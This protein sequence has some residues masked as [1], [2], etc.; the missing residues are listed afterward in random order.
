MVNGKP[1]VECEFIMPTIQPN[2]KTVKITFEKKIDSSW[3]NG[4]YMANLFV[5][6]GQGRVL[7]VDSADF[8]V[9][10][11]ESVDVT[12]VYFT[13]VVAGLSIGGFLLGRRFL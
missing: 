11:P 3:P 9:G 4:R 6:D 10:P 2:Q 12:I 8:R 1:S 7:D 5:I 13:I